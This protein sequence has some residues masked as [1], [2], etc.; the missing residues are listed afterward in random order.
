M[1]YTFFLVTVCWLLGSIGKLQAQQFTYQPI[2]PFFGGTN[3]FNY[4]QILSSANAQ[5]SLQDP[6]TLPRDQRTELE[7]F[8]D[9]VNAQVLSQLSR[10][11]TSAQVEGLNFEE[12]GSFTAGEFAIEIFEG[13]EGLVI[14]ILD[15]TTGE[16]SQIIVPN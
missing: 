16:E 6:N 11:L 3:A 12:P 9:N 5:N 10:S 7:R 2:S 14:N 13:A 4:Q 1:K 15:T 8:A